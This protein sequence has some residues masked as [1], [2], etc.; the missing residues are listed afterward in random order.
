MVSY[1]DNPSFQISP[2][3]LDK[4]YLSWSKSYLLFIKVRGLQRYITGDMKK[5][6]V[7]DLEYNV[8][9]SKNFLIMSWLINS[10]QPHITRTYLL[11][12]T[13]AKKC[14]TASLTYSQVDN[15]TQIYELKKIHGTK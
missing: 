14:N 7:G 9:D 10:I 5:P 1:S 12:D 13:V 15:Y 4:T 6:D 3:K 8:W 11:F 2:V